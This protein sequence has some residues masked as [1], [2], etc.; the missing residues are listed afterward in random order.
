MTHTEKRQLQNLIQKLPK[1]NL[2]LVVEIVQCG[3]PAGKPCGEEIFVDLEKTGKEIAV[4]CMV[5][6]LI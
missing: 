3:R 4:S 5:F 1:G 6:E 2:V